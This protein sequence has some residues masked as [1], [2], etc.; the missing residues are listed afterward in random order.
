M[1]CLLST[2]VLG[3]VT[4]PAMAAAVVDGTVD[5]S[6][7]SAL[8]VQTVQTQ[9][10][11]NDGTGNGGG[12]LNAG[13][14][15]AIAG[16][17]LYVML[18]G[19]LEH[20]FNKMDIFIDSKVGG[21]NVLSGT[22]DYDFDP[23]GGF[24]S[25][26]FGGLTFDTGFTAD[27]HVFARFGN[28]VGVSDAFEIDLVDRAGGVSALVN[29]GTIAPGAGGN[30]TATFITQNVNFAINNTNSAGVMGGTAAADA[31]AAEDVTTGIEFSV[32]LVDI[33]NPGIGDTI[34]IAAM[35]NNGDHNFLSNQ[36]LGGLPA[37]QGNL[38]G[39]G[40]GNFTGSLSGI[41][42]NSFAGDQFFSITVVP[43]PTSLVF[44]MM[45]LLGLVARGR[46]R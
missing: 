41:D 29:G 11:D 38:G 1:R 34:R 31:G 24:I 35:Y 17:R 23:G 44:V 13:Y 10:G 25:S 28:T 16:D 22:P 36:V 9:F 43:E 7:G 12:E 8:A 40:A 20:N 46:R 32:A 42:F 21:E 27:Y 3:F 18:T 5:A 30:N 15:L 39:D 2:L 45:G 26:N 33:G 6:Y 19:N 4:V 37:P 14:G